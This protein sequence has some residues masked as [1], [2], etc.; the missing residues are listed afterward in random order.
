DLGNGIEFLTIDGITRMELTIERIGAG[1]DFWDYL[2]S[3]TMTNNI[4]TPDEATQTSSGINNDGHYI[5]VSTTDTFDHLV[6]M[7][8]ATANFLIDNVEVEIFAIPEPATW[9][10]M[11]VGGLFVTFRRRR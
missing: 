6:L 3:F 10:L 4:G 1:N 8:T 5:S 9:A 11:C 2:Y 7:Q